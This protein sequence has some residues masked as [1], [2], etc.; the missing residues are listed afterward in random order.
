[1][2]VIARRRLNEFTEKYP[3]TENALVGWYSLIDI[4]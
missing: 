2:H 1:M 4:K 3:G